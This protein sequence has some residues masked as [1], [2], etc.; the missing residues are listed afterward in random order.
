MSPCLSLVP[1]LPHKKE[2]PWMR[3]HEFVVFVRKVF[4]VPA[5]RP[6][7]TLHLPLV[8]ACLSHSPLISIPILTPCP[9]SPVCAPCLSYVCYPMVPWSRHSDKE[10]P[11]AFPRS[12]PVC[13]GRPHKDDSCL[14][15]TCTP[16]VLNFKCRPDVS[17]K[18]SARTNTHLP[19]LPI[20]RQLSKQPNL[21]L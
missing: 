11:N 6:Q 13:G 21:N 1:Q 12:S 2:S 17:P 8:T 20:F 3:T 18:S 19:C 16:D 14:L 5:I 15:S 9:L 4:H 7:S 10:A